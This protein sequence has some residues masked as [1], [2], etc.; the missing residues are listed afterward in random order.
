M[1]THA[2]D[3][4]TTM[5]A[6]DTSETTDTHQAPHVEMVCTCT[7]MTI[8]VIAMTTVEDMVTWIVTTTDTVI[9]VTEIITVMIVV[10]I[11]ML[12]A[13]EMISHHQASEYT[14]HAT[15]MD[16]DIHAEDLI[17][18]MIATDTSETTD[19]HQ[20]PH[21][22][23]VCTC[24]MMTIVV[25]A[26]TTVEDMVTWTVTTTDMA[27]HVMEIITVMTV[28]PTCHTTVKDMVKIQAALVYTAHATVMD[29]DI[30]AEV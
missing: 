16:M 10:P 24:T 4:I 19:T 22:E 23:M 13:A 1:D 2:V 8:V 9:H 5:I 3:L 29:T 21:V 25:I 7:T 30:H 17:T 26:T 11:C 27:I 28:E 12:T 14:A 18:T 15:V 20:A 6:T